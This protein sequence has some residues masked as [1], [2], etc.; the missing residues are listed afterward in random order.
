MPPGRF[1]VRCTIKIVRRT[2]VKHFQEKLRAPGK[3]PEAAHTE[4]FYHNIRRRFRRAS[5][6]LKTDAHPISPGNVS[7]PGRQFVTRP[8]WRGKHR[9][10]RF[11]RQKGSRPERWESPLY[12]TP[13]RSDV[14][15][16]YAGRFSRNAGKRNSEYDWRPK[17]K[18]R[19][20]ENVTYYPGPDCIRNG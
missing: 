18:S 10:R 8:G 13:P 11:R 14:T 6:R 16:Y 2:R 19:S 12:P 3:R 7:S 5:S 17:A 20:G 1:L 4:K 9:R 15:V